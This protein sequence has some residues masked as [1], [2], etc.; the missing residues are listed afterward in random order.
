[1]KPIVLMVTHK[2]EVMYESEFIKPILVNHKILAPKHW[3]RDNEDINISHKNPNYCELTALYWAWK[4]LSDDYTHVGLFHYRRMLAVKKDNIFFKKEKYKVYPEYLEKFY[5]DEV[6][7]QKISQYKLLLPLPEK[8][9]MT[10]AKHYC[11][12][13]IPED[14]DLLMQVLEEKMPKNFQNIK[15]YFTQTKRQFWANMFVMERTL[16]NQYAAWL[17]EILFELE[18]RLPISQHPYQARVFGF[19]AERLQNLYVNIIC[20]E[21]STQSFPCVMSK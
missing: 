6:L 2:P 11:C 17:F 13:H 3:L 16:F 19:M 8:Q 10:I 18:N 1:M 14:W 5:S 9:N 4:N 20:P 7:L 15:A 12:R 21:T